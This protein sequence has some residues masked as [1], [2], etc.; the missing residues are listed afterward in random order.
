MQAGGATSLAEMGSPPS[1]IQ[2][3]GQWSSES[4]HIYI[5]KNPVLIQAMLWAQHNDP[6]LANF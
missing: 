5:Q 3:I 2:A 1:L 4:F 6:Q